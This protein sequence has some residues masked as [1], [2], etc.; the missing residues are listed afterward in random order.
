M[1]QRIQLNAGWFALVVFVFTIAASQDGYTEHTLDIRRAKGKN[2]CQKKSEIEKLFSPWN[3]IL[4]S[5]LLSIDGINLNLRVKFAINC[6]P[7]DCE[8][9][10]LH[11]SVTTSD[12]HGDGLNEANYL[13]SINTFQTDFC[14]FKRH[15]FV[16][17]TATG[18]PKFRRRVKI[19]KHNCPCSY[20]SG[21]TA[22]FRLPLIG[23]LLFK[24]N[25][26]P[27]T[28]V[29]NS[30][31]VIVS[32]RTYNTN[33]SC[34]HRCTGNIIN[35]ARLPYLPVNYYHG[36]SLLLC[37][38]NARSVRNKTAAIM[39]YI[40]DSNVDLCAITET[41][42][43]PDDAAVRAELC[44]NG[45]KFLDN[46]RTG[47]R[48]G[49]IG[50]LYRDSLQVKTVNSGEKSSFEFSECIVTSSSSRDLRVVNIYRPPYSGEHK[51]TTS[52]FFTE[53]ANYIDLLFTEAFLLCKEQ[54]IITGDFNI[55]IDSPEQPDARTFL[56]LLDS[57]GLKQNVMQPTHISGHTLDLL[58]TRISEDIIKDPPVV[59]RF[60]SDHASILCNLQQAKPALTIVSRT[61]RKIK[62][63]NLASLEADLAMSGL[64]HFE[65]V[66]LANDIG[67]F[68][69]RKIEN[70]RSDINAVQFDLDVVPKDLVLNE[71]QTFGD[72]QQLTEEDV[73]A[74]VQKSGKKSCALDPMP[75]GLVVKCLG[76][77][78]PVLTRIN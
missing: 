31:P 5:G 9:W 22:T 13:N 2:Y 16:G 71:T 58:I 66:S 63:V 54:L 3:C 10:R 46:P 26:G 65:K 55:H 8:Q 1:T 34:V 28:P 72:F 23:D 56:D 62:S 20:Y 11:L 49:G 45:F 41:W 57:F 30:I 78:L 35:V 68:F 73:T 19:K 61:Y 40:R 76:T 27:I 7:N 24:L 67:R 69:V 52:V 48:G 77:L 15:P 17:N 47:R 18:N 12:Y 53:F 43:T 75:T 32:S 39:D 44:P 37:V 33:R 60:I 51:V 70:I 36:N 21:S 25:P 14:I 4:E 74:L 38:L 29:L 59:D 64:Y 42:L 50:L 6:M